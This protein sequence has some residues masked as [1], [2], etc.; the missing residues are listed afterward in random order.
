M[1]GGEAE[2]EIREVLPRLSWI[3]DVEFA[4]HPMLIGRH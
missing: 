1:D 3:P 4:V 2:M